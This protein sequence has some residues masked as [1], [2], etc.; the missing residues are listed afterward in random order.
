VATCPS[1]G[2]ENPEHARFCLR[3]NVERARALFADCG[4]EVYLH[5]IDART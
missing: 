3:P 5:Q 1:C 4:A 2:E